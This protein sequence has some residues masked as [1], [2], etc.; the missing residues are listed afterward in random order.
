MLEKMKY[1][2]NQN[3]RKEKMHSE[4]FKEKIR[5]FFQTDDHYIQKPADDFG[6]QYFF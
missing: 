4:T 2:S 5:T 6:Y 3:N 1:E